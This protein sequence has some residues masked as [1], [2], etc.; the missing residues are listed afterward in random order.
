MS[1]Q[2]SVGNSQGLLDGAQL[3]IQPQNEEEAKI[4]SAQ[5]EEQIKALSDGA[6]PVK[7]RE[8]TAANIANAGGQWNFQNLVLEGKFLA[9]NQIKFLTE[10]TLDKD[11]WWIRG[12]VNAKGQPHGICRRI[13]PNGWWIYEGQFVD[14]QLSGYGR[15][16]WEDGYYIGDWKDGERHGL[17]TL[18]IHDR[19][20]VGAWKDSMMHGEGKVTKADG[21][22]FTGNFEKDKLNGVRWN[23]L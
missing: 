1:D 19:T 3:I 13:R 11:G 14:G 9:D 21:K 4:S 5:L 12:Q 2:N 17:G 7:L 10:W 22:V 23:Q 18:V 20:Y 6:Y 8:E 15:Q 16:I